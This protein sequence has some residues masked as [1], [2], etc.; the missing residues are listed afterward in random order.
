M[1][2]KI[3]LVR[4]LI[5]GHWYTK[6]LMLCDCGRAFTTFAKADVR[7][8]VCARGNAPVHPRRRDQLREWWER[9]GSLYPR[10]RDD[11]DFVGI[12][13]EQVEPSVAILDADYIDYALPEEPSGPVFGAAIVPVVHKLEHA[14]HG[15]CESC[16]T[17][18]VFIQW[19]CLECQ[20]LMCGDCSAE[21]GCNA[22]MTLLEIGFVFDLSRERIRQIEEIGLRK[23]QKRLAH[24]ELDKAA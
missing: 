15:Q 6:S 23:M 14:G 24:L 4:R 16:G 17:K 8:V 11:L 5:R 2:Q 22:G 3:G 7:C 12:Q 19:G 9:Y 18:D 10:Y 21:H 20:L 13:P 1:S